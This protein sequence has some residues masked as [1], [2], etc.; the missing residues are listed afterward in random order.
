MKIQKDK[1]LHFTVCA[2]VAFVIAVG[3]G[4]LS[5][6]F[7]CAAVAGFCSGFAIG[8]GKEYGDSKAVGNKWDWHDL[9]ADTLGAITGAVVGGLLSLVI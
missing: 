1:M 8:A 6:D 2:F 4:W 5:E 7:F 3:I 9:S